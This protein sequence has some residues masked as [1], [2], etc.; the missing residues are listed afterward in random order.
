MLCVTSPVGFLNI[1]YWKWVWETIRVMPLI[2]AICQ[3][4]SHIDYF[5]F[6]IHLKVSLIFSRLKI[7]YKENPQTRAALTKTSLHRTKLLMGTQMDFMTT[8]L[9]CVH[10]SFSKNNIMQKKKKKGYDD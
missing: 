7:F 6:K 4:I 9:V 1:V 10:V 3:I 2:H 5:S 8:K